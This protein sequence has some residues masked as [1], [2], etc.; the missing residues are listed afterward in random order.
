[1]FGKKTVDSVLASFR[2]T[3]AEL[4]AI[5]EAQSLEVERLAD[6]IAVAEIDRDIAGREANRAFVVAGKIESL[7]S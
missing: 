3:I 2:K 4:Q 1:M 6:V 7:I 5:G